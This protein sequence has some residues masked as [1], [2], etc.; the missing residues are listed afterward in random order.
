MQHAGPI[1]MELEERSYAFCTCGR[2]QRLP[3]CD[4]AHKGSDFRP[5]LHTCERAGAAVVCGCRRSGNFP[6]CDG[7]HKNPAA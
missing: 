5:L 3:F 7:S 4:G 2:S 1:R 6:Y